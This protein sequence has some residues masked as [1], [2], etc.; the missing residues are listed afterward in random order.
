MAAFSRTMGVPPLAATTSHRVDRRARYLAASFI[1][2]LTVTVHRV[3]PNAGARRASKVFRSSLRACSVMSIFLLFHLVLCVRPSRSKNSTR[4]H[5]VASIR[6]QVVQLRVEE[7]NIAGTLEKTLI[8]RARQQV[9]GASLHLALSR[10]KRSIATRNIRINTE[11][12][13]RFLSWFM[14][15]DSSKATKSW[16]TEL[17]RRS[18]R[19]RMF[20]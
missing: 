14:R 15:S 19:S 2:V 13:G 6:N 11:R 18:R 3:A 8:K 9:S 1:R 12:Q 10:R 5:Q 16:T 7:E 20:R 4:W 17:R